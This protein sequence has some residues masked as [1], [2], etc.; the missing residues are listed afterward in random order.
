MPQILYVILLSVV[1]II[2]IDA[3]T[4]LAV[5]PTPSI[6]HQIVFRPFTLELVKR[7]HEVVVLTTDPIYNKSEAPVNLTE[8]DVHDISYDIWYKEKEASNII[9]GN[10]NDIIPQMRVMYGAYLKFLEKLLRHKEVQ[11]IINRK[12]KFDL[13]IHEALCTPVLIF[14]HILNVPAIQI[15][16]FGVVYDVLDIIGAPTHPLLYPIPVQQKIYDLTIWDKLKQLYIF[17]Q[18]VKITQNFEIG[19]DAVLQKVIGAKIPKLKDLKKNVEVVFLNIYPFWDMNRPAPP[20][21]IYL[22]GLH[23]Q[24]EKKLPH[25]LKTYLDSSTNGVIYVSFGTNIE[26]TSLPPHKIQILINVFSKL[27]HNI[28]WKWN[29]DELPGRSE[30]I[31]ISKWFPQADIL[32]HPKVKLFI[33]QGGLQ[34]TD[35]AITGEVPLIGIPMFAD[36]WYNVEQYVHHGIGVRVDMETINEYKF[37]NAIKEI[38]N[39]DSYRRN[40]VRLKNIIQDRPQ[41][42]LERA[43]WWTEYVIRHGGAKHLR[44][45]AAN[46]SWTEYLE[47]ELIFYLLTTCLTITA[48][49]IYTVYRILGRKKIKGKLKSK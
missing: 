8:I 13:L 27:K 20:N 33:T 17:Y 42:S 12:K 11:K 26:P 7:G 4:I 32:R 9:K 34:S 14:S 48:L 39:N 43:V 45:P 47:L 41:S 46:M 3:A 6:S 16:S 5:Y 30:N 15:S 40:I 38:L 31:K 28:L 25:H 21:L 10:I 37:R 49:V 29:K 44:S 36:Q 18:I 35:E 24:P 22:G 1:V 2:Q 19:S 23:Q